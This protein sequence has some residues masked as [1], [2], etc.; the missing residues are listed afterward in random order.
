MIGGRLSS[1]PTPTPLA[2]LVVEAVVRLT[3]S[4]LVQPVL[5]PDLLAERVAEVSMRVAQA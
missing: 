1:V 4:H 2:G 3:V 5:P